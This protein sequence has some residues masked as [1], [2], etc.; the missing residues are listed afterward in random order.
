VSRGYRLLAFLQWVGV[1]PSLEELGYVGEEFVGAFIV[2]NGA[3][4][5]RTPEFRSQ[6]PDGFLERPAE[7]R[8]LK[9][10]VQLLSSFGIG[11][12]AA[13]AALKEG[14][15]DLASDGWWSE[16][17][18]GVAKETNLVEEQGPAVPGAVVFLVCPFGFRIEDSIFRVII[19]EIQEEIS[20]GKGAIRKFLGTC[21]GKEER[22]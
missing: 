16:V 7:Y 18:K 19:G 12:V 21:S 14:C 17:D 22:M 5:P 8:S 11:E 4:P 10:S 2:V 20:L 15:A 9:F 3:R 1:L 13:F 6:V